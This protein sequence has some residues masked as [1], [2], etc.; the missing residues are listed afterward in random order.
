[1]RVN[2]YKDSALPENRVDVYYREQDAE[3]MGLMAFLET[4]QAIVGREEQAVTCKGTKGKS[5]KGTCYFRSE[6]RTAALCSISPVGATLRRF[7]QN[8]WGFSMLHLSR[9]A[10]T[11]GISTTPLP[12]AGRF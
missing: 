3:I 1:M 8:R 11:T 5:M 7:P 9:D 12:A 2:Y 10:G 6:S 4:G